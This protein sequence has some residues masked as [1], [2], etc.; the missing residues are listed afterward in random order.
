MPAVPL[1]LAAA[2]LVA[3]A[4]VAGRS[5]GVPPAL[6]EVALVGAMGAGV[7]LGIGARTFWRGTIMEALT[8]SGGRYVLFVGLVAFAVVEAHAVGAALAE[9]AP[10]TSLVLLVLPV[11][12]AA[13]ALV[14]A[15]RA[16]RATPGV[17]IEGKERE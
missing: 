7:L 3:L 15:V 5:G 13:V 4:L 9:G 1:A 10:A 16:V 11:V 8:G 14:S 6:T 17:S 12:L 2:V